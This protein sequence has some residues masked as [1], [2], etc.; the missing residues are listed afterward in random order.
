MDF[1]N[2][3]GDDR[4]AFEDDGTSF[5]D[6]LEN[7]HTSFGSLRLRFD[8]DLCPLNQVNLERLLQ[9]ETLDQLELCQLN[10]EQILLPFSAKA[11]ALVYRIH[12]NAT[13][14]TNFNS[15]EIATKDLNLTIFLHDTT[16]NWHLLPISFLQRV[17]EVGHFQRLHF[18]LDGSLDH[19]DRFEANKAALVVEALV[20]ALSRN[21]ELTYLRLKDYDLINLEE[22]VVWSTH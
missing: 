1:F 5:L 22:F 4:F 3:R 12:S 21:P 20:H 15:L 2:C 7:R 6:A 8:A 16:N 14:P 10:E 18:A 19:L 11:N 9:L 13:H 17:A